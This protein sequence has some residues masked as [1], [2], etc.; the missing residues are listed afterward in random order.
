MHSLVKKKT[1]NSGWD[2]LFLFL[3][4]WGKLD[5]I[6]FSQKRLLFLIVGEGIM[7]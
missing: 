2:V 7:L 6:V 3:C 4:F 5:Q 1:Q